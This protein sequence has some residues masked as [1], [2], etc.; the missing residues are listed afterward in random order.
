MEKRTKIIATIGPACDSEDMLEK[1]MLA[2]MD[3][4]RINFS[5]AT[6]N[7]FAT[8][9]DTIDKLN[10]KHNSD[11]KTLIDLQ[12]PRIR[13]GTLPDSGVELKE[14]STV[15][16]TTDYSS[17]NQAIYINDPYLHS[18]IEVGHPL[19][20]ANGDLELT[21]TEKKGAEIT[22]KVIR[23]GILYS[24]KGINVPETNLT[25][26]GLTEKDMRDIAFG[27]EHG[28]NYI[29]LS[30]VKNEKDIHKAREA[31]LGKNILLCA[32]IEIKQ[33]INNLDEIIKASDVI[34][35]AR[36]D[37]G[38][39]LPLEQIPLLQ[40]KIIKLCI[41]LNKP[42]V[43]AT[44]MFMSMVNH[45]RPTRAEISDAANAILDGASMLMLSDETAFGKYPIQAVEYLVKTILEIES[46][47]K[48]NS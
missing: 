47:Q 2:G 11:V 37:L 5:H 26:S 46:F 14:N 21:V 29:A 39:E 22:A 45:Y 7:E 32:K 41:Q 40:K 12:G 10:R 6:H 31:T 25:T 15:V 38:I 4:A 27:L 35:I 17:H 42:A 28:A 9:W 1:L 23:G 16:F 24:R 30:F 18:D 8:I 13:V 33:A 36:G 48:T 44:Q 43:V 34:M 3:I 20:L 19:Y